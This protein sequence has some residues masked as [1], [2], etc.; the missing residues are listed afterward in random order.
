MGIVNVTYE[1]NRIWEIDL[2]RF[3]AI[4]LMV[5]FHL[6]YDL[7]EF[8]NV[9]VEYE[10]GFWYY[11]GAVSAILF[12]FVSGISSGFSRNTFRRGLKVFG[13]GMVIT[14]VTYFFDSSQYIRFGILHFLGVSM[15]LFPLLK[16]VNNWLLFIIGVFL[17]VVGKFIETMTVNTFLLLPFGFMYGGFASMDYYPLFPYISY[18]ILGILCYKLFYYKRRSLFGFNFN[19]S[20]VQTVGKHSLIIYLLHQ[21]IILGIM[22]IIS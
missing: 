21:P 19:V 16:K 11:I 14:I 7:N 6:V 17:F 15:M 20:L 8:A 4:V 13:F 22:Y 5:T 9:N 1:K 10:F 3:I 18:F 2:L 12:I